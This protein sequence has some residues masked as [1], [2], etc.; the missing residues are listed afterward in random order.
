MDIVTEQQVQ[1]VIGIL[2]SILSSDNAIRKRAENQLQTLRV[3]H[4]N[5]FVI[6]ILRMFRQSQDGMVKMLG[7]V[8][9]RQMFSNLSPSRIQI[10]KRLTPESQEIC[11][12]ELLEIMKK[13][14][15]LALCKRLGDV[16]SELAVAIFTS[17]EQGSWDQLVPFLFECVMG[18]NNRT[19]SS[20]FHTLNEL[21][22][23][24]HEEMLKH[25]ESLFQVFRRQME[26]NDADVKLSCVQACC[27]MIGIIDTPDAMY[28]GELLSPIFK[29][30]AWI[31]EKNEVSGEEAL[32]ALRDLTESE[33]KFFKP[34]LQLAYNFVTNIC[35]LNIENSG[36]K[37]L[38]I[39]FLVCIAERLS[40]EMENAKAFAEAVCNMI[41]KVM[42][43]IDSEIEESWFVPP[44]GY[45]EQE[46][47]EGSIDIDY[48]KRGRKLLSRLLEGVGDTQLMPYVLTLIQQ[49]LN[50]SNKDW[51]IRYAGLMTV[52]EVAQYI[53]DDSR[54]AT[55]IPILQSSVG[56]EFHSKIR[57]AAYHCI[58]KLS[59][60]YEEEFQR[61]HHA[62]IVP[63]L[64]EG[65]TDSVP[66]VAACACAALNKFMENAGHTIANQ[67]TPLIIP[68]LIDRISSQNC[69][70]IIEIALSALAS[71]AEAC[72]EEFAVYYPQ[73]A[74][75]LFEIIRNYKS[76]IYKLLRGK[77]IECLTLMCNAVGRN[78]FSRNASQV[79]ALLKDIQD[80][81]LEENDPLKAYLLSAWQRISATLKSDFAPYLGDVIPGLLKAA[82]LQAEVSISTEPELQIDIE[83]LMKSDT[84]KKLSVTTSDI[85]DKEVA[86]QTL[87]TIIDVLK[88]AYSPHVDRT[89]T[90]ILPL[91]GY[92]VNESI[93]SAAASICA[94]LIVSLK[95]SGHP[96]SLSFVVPLA[97]RFLSALW[98]AASQEFE[99]ETLVAQLEAIKM[100]IETPKTV[101][102]SAEEV[103]NVGE[104]V[105]KLLEDSLQ[106]RSRHQFLQAEDS[107]NEEGVE[108]PNKH[109]E[110]SLQSAVSEVLGVLFKTHRTQSL[111]I[112]E[113]LYANVLSKFLAPG[114]TDEDH[115]FAIF[116][117]DDIV[118]FVGQDLAVSKWSA[119]AE[120][121]LRY[122]CDKNDSVRQAAVYGL[123][124]LA[125]HSNS[126]A[127][128]GMAQQ[129][130]DSLNKAIAL[131]LGRSKKTYEH[132]RDNAISAVGKIIRYQPMCVDLNPLVPSWVDLLPLKHD[133]TEARIMHDLLVDIAISNTQL[134]VGSSH[135]RLGKIIVLFADVLETKLI[136]QHTVPKVKT[137][138][139]MLQSSYYPGLPEIW[140]NLTVTQKS[141]LTKLISN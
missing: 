56:Q 95:E 139:A 120:A 103:N 88:G 57:W 35:Q 97:R 59:E 81:Q 136:D 122:S 32:I 40:I 104:R 141:K 29:A 75:Y 87:L 127:F 43:T 6:C 132:A 74:P 46:D 63:L 52:A 11:K 128:Q 100:L 4:P 58:Q 112:V 34:Q 101:Y 85:E 55:L 50:S 110:D 99:I 86:L 22:P 20:G 140:E 65:T 94:S 9:L 3:E 89:A 31:I 129:I 113:F 71:L 47:E 30:I 125:T 21:F 45:Q 26:N 118:E 61:G 83:S 84:K 119:L 8:I 48:A 116:V 96:N 93:R 49:S 73:M 25:K 90:I 111:N 39:E 77:A 72:K 10:W 107:D 114:S 14:N 69:S 13:E 37:Y 17:D 42:L 23:F 123:G 7:A 137:F 92:P 135:E 67:Y 76:S 130:L 2:T 16:I 126:Q 24:F 115:K 38:A 12:S 105:L 64:L 70:F 5:E 51:R 102:L 28:F 82:N 91:V 79:I 131:P 62:I 19:I 41:F 53:D 108:E 134:T 15:M 44:E 80:H 133:K 124:M 98:I 27:N 60:D 1:G 78:V 121:L 109:E 66:R 106:R 33:P 68:K 117:I 18:N 54:I 138:I 36:L